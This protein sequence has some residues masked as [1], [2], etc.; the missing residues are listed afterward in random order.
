MRQLSAELVAGAPTRY[1]AVL[2]V[3]RY[4]RAN[5]TYRLDSPVP[6]RGQDAVDHFLFEARTGFCEQFASAEA[7][8]L[9]AAGIPA[10]LATGFSGG[11]GTAD[12]RLL[13]AADAHAWVEVWYPGVGWAASDRRPGPSSP[14]ARAR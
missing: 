4:L 10:R 11:S 2:A 12:G 5:A 6:P 7:V 3:E 9:R 1:D 13:K 8:L 14:T